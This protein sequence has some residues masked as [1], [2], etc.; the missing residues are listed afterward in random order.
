MD[1]AEDAPLDRRSASTRTA[2]RTIM[3]IFDRD[4]S[5]RY[6]FDRRPQLLMA[7]ARP[8]EIPT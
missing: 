1:L 6:P 8:E 7:A 3:W 2:A 4:A 5:G